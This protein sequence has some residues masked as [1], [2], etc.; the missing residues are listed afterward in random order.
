[1]AALVLLATLSITGAGNVYTGGPEKPP[2]IV[3]IIGFEAKNDGTQPA[4]LRV[5]GGKLV[6]C[7]DD[8]GLARRPVIRELAVAPA[9]HGS[10]DATI[11]VPAGTTKHLDLVVEP[12][13]GPRSCTVSYRMSL[14]VDGK[15]RTADLPL[16]MRFRLPEPDPLLS[17]P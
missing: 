12:F 5:T 9:E 4:T 11:T 7:E 6:G 1:M 3:Q 16:E 10:L 2:A 15:P 14:L 13:A 8:P 17:P